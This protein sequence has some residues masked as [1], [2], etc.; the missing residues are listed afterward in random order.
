MVAFAVRIL[1]LLLLAGCES[2]PA[3]ARDL[4]R[5]LRAPDLAHDLRAHDLPPERRGDLPPFASRFVLLPAGSFQMGSAEDEP[6]REPGE[7]RRTVTLSR[8]FELLASEVSEALFAERMGYSPPGSCGP[9]C[10]VRHVS[11]H[12][13]AAF[14]NALSAEEKLPACYT[15]TGSMNQVSCAAGPL[16]SLTEP[17]K[18]I[19]DCPG[20]RLPTE[21]EWEY[22]YRA[23]TTTALYSG[24]LAGS[25]SGAD[26]AA[27]AIAWYLHSAGGVAHA[28]GGK[29]ANAWGLHDLAGNVAEW[30]HDGYEL[31]GTFEVTDPL[32]PSESSQRVV[33]GGSF[34]SEVAALRAA[35]RAHDTPGSRRGDRGFRLARTRP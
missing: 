8:A 25:C 33:R 22:A 21:A 18:A 30:S 20:Y 9:A 23:G 2:A 17:G 15:C 32:G 24:E 35:A 11:W 27:D 31:S 4:G 14:A 13:A 6:C 5:D 34:S 16:Y 1:A 10:P 29:Q 7:T 19:Y 28:I 26:P 3:A 12:E